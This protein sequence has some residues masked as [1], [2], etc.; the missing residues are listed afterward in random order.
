[1]C[2][3]P[4]FVCDREKVGGGGDVRARA[5]PQGPEPRAPESPAQH[6]GRGPR[7]KATL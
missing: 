2:A 6:G 5:R 3:M 1:M 4:R 7:A